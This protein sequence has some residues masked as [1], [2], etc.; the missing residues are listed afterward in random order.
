MDYSKINVVG[1]IPARYNSSRFPGK[2]LVDIN[3]KS[4]IQRVYEQSMKTKLLSQ[5]YVAT[6]DV[7]I[8]DHVKSFTNNVLMTSVNHNNGTE[9]IAEAIDILEENGFFFDIVVNVQGDEPYIFPQQIDEVVSILLNNSNAE[10]ATL[11]QRTSCNDTND[12]NRVKAVLDK[13]KKALYFSRQ[14]I[15]YNVNT[16]HKQEYLKHIGLY[17][18]RK[19]ILKEIVKLPQSSLELSESLEQLRWLDNGYNVFADYSD[20]KTVSIDT[21]ED[22]AEFCS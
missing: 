7:R 14:M 15:P 12:P 21:R 17:A 4:M 8:F 10:I 5:V 6:D 19:N 11:V 20:Y 1:I 13:N 3:G 16:N 22:L 9:R 18:F 2:A